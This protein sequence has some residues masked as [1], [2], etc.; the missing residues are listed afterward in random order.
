MN[1][2]FAT[3]SSH[4][5]EERQGLSCRKKSA[6]SNARRTQALIR[7]ISSLQFKK[8]SRLFQPLPLHWAIQAP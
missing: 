8:K 2:T 3:L 4:E 7:I 6:W 1:T 5:C